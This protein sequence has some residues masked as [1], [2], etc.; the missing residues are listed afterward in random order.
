[1]RDDEQPSEE[2]K[3]EVA[4]IINGKPTGGPLSYQVGLAEDAGFYPNCGGSLM[5]HV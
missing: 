3:P 5:H 2:E 4:S 1:M